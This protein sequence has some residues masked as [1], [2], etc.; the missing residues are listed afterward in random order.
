[1]RSGLAALFRAHLVRVERLDPLRQHA[2][3]AG[4]GDAGRLRRQWHAGRRADR[5]PRRSRSCAPRPGGEGAGDD[6]LACARAG[7]LRSP[8]AGRGSACMTTSVAAACRSPPR[9]DIDDLETP[10]PHLT[11]DDGVKLHYEE[12]G[13]GAPIVFVHEFAGDGRSWEHQLRYFGRRYRCIAYNA[14]GFPPS[15]VPDGVERYSQERARDD[16]KAV[17]DALKIDKAHIVG[18]SMGGFAALHFG[19]TYP[20]RAL[21]LVVGGCGYG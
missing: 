5:R 19:F 2:G 4:G 16:I 7:G 8:D 13:A 10:M 21:S 9:A 18:L 17:L 11:T 14:R 12:V 3:L 1:M 15:D 6:Q 20:A